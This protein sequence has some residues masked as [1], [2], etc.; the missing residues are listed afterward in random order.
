M[1]MYSL[2][3]RK[4]RWVLINDQ[5]G[6]VEDIYSHRTKGEVIAL[7]EKRFRNVHCQTAVYAACGKREHLLSFPRQLTA[8]PLHALDRVARLAYVRVLPQG[9][10]CLPS[11]AAK[12]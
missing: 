11:G 6:T 8:V 1:H 3:W 12:S 7:L 4:D 2:I 5:T 9:S 10:G